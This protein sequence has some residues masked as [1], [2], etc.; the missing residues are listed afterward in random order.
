MGGAIESNVYGLIEFT[1]AE[2]ASTYTYLM[3][4]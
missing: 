4:T 1:H 3:E 2:I